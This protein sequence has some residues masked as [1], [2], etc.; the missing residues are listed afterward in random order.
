MRTLYSLFVSTLLFFSP[1]LVFASTFS[2][3]YLPTGDGFY[4]QFTPKSGTIHYTHVDESPCNGTTDYVSTTVVGSRDSYALNISN[5]PNG[6]TISQITLKPCA[7]NNSGGGSGAVKVFYRLNGSTSPDVGT[8]SLSGTAPT[9]LATTSIAVNILRT[10]STTIESGVVFSSGTKGARISR[11]AT[12]ITYDTLNA[13]ASLSVSSTSYFT[14]GLTWTDNATNE[15]GYRIDRS[16]DGTNYSQISTTSANTTTFNDIGLAYSTTYYYRVYAFNAGGTSTYSYTSG[17]TDTP[18]SPAGPTNL[19]AIGTSTTSTLLTW[20]DNSSI[21]DGFTILRWNNGY[22][23]E[24]GSVSTNTTQYLDTGLD[25]YTVYSYKVRA[26]N[27]FAYGGSSDN[28][29]ASPSNEVIYHFY[30]TVGAGEAIGSTTDSV[31]T[32]DVA[33]MK[34]TNSGYTRIF[35]PFD[36][37]LIP[38]NASITTA[39]LAIRPIFRLINDTDN[40]S[41]LS[42]IGPTTQAS[43]TTLFGNDYF[44]CGSTSNPQLLA[45][46]ITWQDSWASTSYVYFNLNSLGTSTISKG[47]NTMLGIREGHDIEG[48]PYQSY[49]EWDFGLRDVD[50]FKNNNGNTLNPYQ[51]RSYLDVKVKGAS[52][53]LPP[54]VPGDPILVSAS[55]T[56]LGISWTDY[57]TDEMGYIVERSLDGVNFTRIGTTSPNETEYYDTDLIANTSYYYRI[58][59]YNLTGTSR[60]NYSPL[61][62]TTLTAPTSPTNLLANSQTNPIN[63]SSSPQLSAIFNDNNSGFYAKNYEFQISTSSIFSSLIYD[64][65]KSSSSH[66]VNIGQRLYFLPSFSYTSGQ[67]YYWRVRFWDNFDAPGD[68]STETATFSIN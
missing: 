67:T 46:K 27:W 66:W 13:P 35:T 34:L 23:E 49:D 55:S 51:Y 11:L 16:T 9:D 44:Q 63:L 40:Q 30:P 64:N 59:V 14:L 54:D 22:Y 37:S 41:Y 36:T 3:T 20:T 50:G 29:S 53:P 48:V 15:N 28:S 5:I 21:E 42:V 56:R 19:V 65:V 58:R 32:G 31:W 24:I 57:Y 43:T 4:K 2:N 25:P 18:T 47:G 62:A 68:W 45:N 33:V 12:A 17:T 1:S 39:T 38:Q 52:L 61:H 6:A 8:Y 7:S 26:F 10:S 60:A